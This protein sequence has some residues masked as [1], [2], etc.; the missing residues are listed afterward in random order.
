VNHN[1]RYFQ[2]TALVS[3]DPH[4]ADRASR[5]NVQ[6]KASYQGIALQLAQKIGV[7]LGI[8]WSSGSPLQ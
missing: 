4:Q 2:R 6:E 1:D 7:V 3:D 8:G 5:C